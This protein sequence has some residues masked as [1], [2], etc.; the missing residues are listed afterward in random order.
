MSTGGLWEPD[1]GIVQAILA[2]SPTVMADL[3]GAD[4]SWAV[5]GLVKAGLTREDIADRLKCS[6]RLVHAVATSPATAICT[7]LMDR[8]NVWTDENRLAAVE[9]RAYRAQLESRIREL[10]EANARVGRLIDAQI[11]G[12]PMCRKCGTPF[13]VGNTYYENGRRRCRNCHR[14]KQQEFR[15]RKAAARRG[16]GPCLELAADGQ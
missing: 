6:V 10:A 7:Y 9:I 4:R 14:L 12:D 15:R 13:D 2:G 5:A 16:G 3:A 1:T 8:E 11:V